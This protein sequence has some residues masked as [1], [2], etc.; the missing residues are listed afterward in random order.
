[1][2]KDKLLDKFKVPPEKVE[3][4]LEIIVFDSKIVYPKNKLDIVKKD[5]SDNKVIECA[6]EAEASF[7]VSGDKHLL[8]IK[9]YK[10]IKIVSPR[11]FLFQI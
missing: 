5:P 1:M 4:F 2:I 9:E 7:V 8:E 10:G 11:E 6:I 3:E